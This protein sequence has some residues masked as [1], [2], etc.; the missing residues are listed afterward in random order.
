MLWMILVIWNFIVFLL[1]GR[2]KQ[3]AKAGEWRISEKT[4]LLCAF[5]LG[6]FGAGLGMR[7]FHHK[8]KHLTFR[9]LIPIA[10]LFNL[11]LLYQLISSTQQLTLPILPHFH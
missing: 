1:Y 6:G 4:L 10:V 11:F 3:R 8:T 7:V 2:D 5:L 9:I